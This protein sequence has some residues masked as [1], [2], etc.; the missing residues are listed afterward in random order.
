MYWVLKTILEATGAPPEIRD[1]LGFGSGRLQTGYTTKS[2]KK[3]RRT[4]EEEETETR[5]EIRAGGKV[6]TDCQLYHNKPDIVVRTTNPDRV[7]VFE[8]AVSR[9]SGMKAQERLKRCRYVTNGEEKVEPDDVGNVVRGRNVVSELS[10]MYG[11]EASLG[12]LVLGCFGEVVRSEEMEN[13]ISLLQSIGMTRR[14]VESCLQ[15]CSYSIALATA[16]LITRRIAE[17]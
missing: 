14:K 9:L 6:L 12:V 3:N 10:K 16:L 2:V 1:G 4:R 17:R 11:C 7:Y 13:S 15:K 8:V 5:I